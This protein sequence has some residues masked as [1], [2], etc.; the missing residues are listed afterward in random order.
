MAVFMANGMVPAVGVAVAIDID[1]DAFRA[2][3]KAV[4]G[5]VNDS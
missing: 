4:S 5:G 1:D 2:Q 3:A